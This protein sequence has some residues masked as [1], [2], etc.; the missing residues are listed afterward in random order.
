MALRGYVDGLLS[1]LTWG[2]VAILLP[3]A[4]LLTGASLPASSVAV[5]AVFDA[6]AAAFLLVRSGVAGALADVVRV[7]ASRRTLAIGLCAL[8]GGPLFMG[9]YV[10]AVM[11]AGPADAL[12]ATATYPVL[13]ALL[14]RPLLRQRLDRI[15]WLGVVATAAGATLIAADADGVRSLIGIAVA[16]VAAAAVALEGIVATRAMVGVATNTVLA[17][18]EL[19]SAAMF[20]LI[21][22]VVP[23]GVTAVGLVVNDADLL[24]PVV[25]AGVIGGYSYVVWYSSI[26]RIG[27]ARAMALNISYAMWGA[28]FAWALLLAPLDPLAVAGCVV[29]TAGAVL[30]ILPGRPVRGRAR[31]GPP[32]SGV[33]LRGLLPRRLVVGGDLHH[34][35]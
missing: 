5:A 11:L 6:A 4:D 2:V 9:G 28:L 34:R 35:R 23:G 7:L 8:L 3:A 12:T 15:G 25:A 29:V 19:V 33:L 22:L 32:A 20:G 1:G 31:P 24:V 27:V 26:R 14:A 18:R 21:V 13:G 17:A 10:A 30:T 16:L